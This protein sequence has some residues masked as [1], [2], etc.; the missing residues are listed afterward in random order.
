MSIE[1]VG[2]ANRLIHGNP[3]V[4][5]RS[6]FIPA[7]YKRSSN[8]GMQKFRIDFDGQRELRLIEPSEFVFTVKPYADLLM[9][10]YLSVTLPNIWSPVYPPSEETGDQWAPYDF[11]WIENIGAH[12]VREVEVICGSH[13][14]ARFSGAYL[15]AAAARDLPA[16]KKRAFDAMTGNTVEVHSPEYAYGR[17]NTYPC[18]FKDEDTPLAGTEPSIRGRKL[19]IPLNAWFAV[20]PEAAFPLLCLNPGLELRV[21]VVLR[22]VQDLF[23]VRDVFDPDNSFPHIRPDFNQP[24]FQ[25]HRFLQTPPW[26]NIQQAAYENTINTWN[27]DIHLVTT[28]AF[29]GAPERRWFRENTHDYLV[30]DVFEYRHDNVANT[31]RVPL[32]SSGMVSGWIFGLQRSDAFMRN[33]WDN[34]TNWPYSRLPGNTKIAGSTSTDAS[35]NYLGPFLNPDGSN[36]G[37][38]LS[39]N[40]RADNRRDILQ[41][42]AIVLDG[43]FREMPQVAEVYNYLEKYARTGGGSV[44]N[45]LFCYQFGLSAALVGGQPTGAIN[46]SAFRHV[47]LELSVFAPPI[48]EENSRF[49][50]QCDDGGNIIAAVQAS[51]WRLSEYTYNATI[52]EERY[53]TIRLIR[54][55][56]GVQFAR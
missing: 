23:R 18:A 13:S 9:D 55:Q 1:A 44:D 50:V 47:D 16:D 14:L 56:V 31:T 32:T 43:S 29:L 51:N 4:D 35:L 41:T 34:Y 36:T 19:Y 21:R 38:F 26:T 30:R 48:D 17:V 53:N 10:A 2:E 12:M 25:M 28:Q 3:S 20:R 7:A 5:A 24:H 40:L 52:W 27:A 45:G 37:I 54:G 42:A 11:K 22:P 8:F 49:Q 39:G 33:E 46:L 6:L 15:A